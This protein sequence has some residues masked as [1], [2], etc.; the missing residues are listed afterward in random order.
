MKIN[1]KKIEGSNVEICVI[2]RGED[3]EPIVFRCQAV[4]D[5]E[6]FDQLC[7]APKPPIILRPGGKRVT[8]TENSKYKFQ[9]GQHNAKRMGY[10]ILKSLEATEGLEWETI[11]LS[12]PDTWNNYEKELKD[13]GFSNIEIMRI[14]NTCMAANCLDE[15][16]LER[17][18]EDFLASQS[19]SNGQ[20][21]TQSDEP[22]SIQSGEPASASELS[23]RESKK[24][25]T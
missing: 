4:L 3:K 25:G 23:R 5:I 21:Y 24:T 1:G 14:I 17:A 7:P 20:S 11:S 13:S 16:R 6:P 9:L 19:G 12:D 2:P 15:A 10:L 22:L 18:R 8:D